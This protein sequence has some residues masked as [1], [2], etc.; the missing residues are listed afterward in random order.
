MFILDSLLI[1]SIRTPT[2][3]PWRWRLLRPLTLLGPDTLRVLVALT[4]RLGRRFLSVT[5]PS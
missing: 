3:I 2:G 5:A 4:A 1:G